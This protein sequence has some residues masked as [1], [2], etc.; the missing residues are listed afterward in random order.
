MKK[1]E[2]ENGENDKHKKETN[3]RINLDRQK[4]HSKQKLNKQTNQRF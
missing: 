4:L 2:K 3:N 1:E